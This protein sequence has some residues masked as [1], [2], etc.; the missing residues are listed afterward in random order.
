MGEGLMSLISDV[1]SSLMK[2]ENCWPMKLDAGDAEIGEHWLFMLRA[3]GILE[4]TDEA[5][6]WGDCGELAVM[7][8]PALLTRLFIIGDGESIDDGL[9]AGMKLLA[10]IKSLDIWTALSVCGIRAETLIKEDDDEEEEEGEFGIWAWL[11]GDETGDV[12][13]VEVCSAIGSNSPP[14]GFGT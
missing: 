6:E 11:A 14:F 3:K 4:A 5:T 1:S 8:L 13:K 10:G 7:K 9:W 2:G 12:F